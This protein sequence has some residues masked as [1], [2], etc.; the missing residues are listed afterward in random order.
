M[1][2]KDPFEVKQVGLFIII[3]TAV[4]NFFLFLNSHPPP[5]GDILRW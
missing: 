5:T 3:F 1:Y 4:A 2:R